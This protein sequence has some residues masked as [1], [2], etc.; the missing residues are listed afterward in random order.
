MKLDAKPSLSQSLTEQ[1]L[2]TNYEKLSKK[3]GLSG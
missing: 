2:W 1:S 3:K